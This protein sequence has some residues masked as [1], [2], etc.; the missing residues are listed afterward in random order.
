MDRLSSNVDVECRIV[1]TLRSDL[2]QTVQ[3]VDSMYEARQIKL[4]N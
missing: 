4:L 1:E 2:E 3:C